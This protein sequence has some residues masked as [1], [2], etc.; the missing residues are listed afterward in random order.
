MSD[1]APASQRRSAPTPYILS[2]FLFSFLWAAFSGLF[3]PHWRS[4]ARG[5][6]TGL[7]GYATRAHIARAALEATAFQTR[8]L[9][10][11]MEAD[12]CEAPL[13]QAD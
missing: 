3:A 4:D 11:A 2:P 10:D 6:V 12:R 5:V 9:A 8:E 7:T 1:P 13:Q